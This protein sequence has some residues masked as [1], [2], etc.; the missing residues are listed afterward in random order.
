MQ[1]IPKRFNV[2]VVGVGGSGSATVYELAKRNKRVLGIERHDIPHDLG[3]S[4]GYTL[5]I[6]LAY[7][8]HPSYV[9]LLH[10]S[11]Q[12]WNEIERRSGEQIL[13]VHGS[14]DAG[15]ADS[16]VFTGAMR[17]AIEFDL[18]HTV[19]T[20]L[21]LNK[22][23]PGYHLPNDTMALYQPQGGYLLPERCIVNYVE[24]AQA[25]GAEVHGREAVLEW[26]PLREGGV[27]VRTDRDVYEADRLVITA[28]AWAGEMVDLM[29]GLLVPERQ[30]LAWL[31]PTKPQHF[32]P[33]NF[34]VFN[35]LVPE[36]RYY[37]FPVVHVPGF[38]FG[39]YHHLE[40]R[41]NPNSSDRSSHLQDEQLLRDFADRYFPDGAGPT[42]S[43]KSCIFTNT[44]DHHFIIDT[45]P[46]YPQVSFAS[47]CS[48]H[49]FKFV[50]VL[51][52]IMADLAERGESRHNIDFFSLARYRPE[53]YPEKRHLQRSALPAIHTGARAG[54][55]DPFARRQGADGRRHIPGLPLVTVGDRYGAGLYGP[56][57][58]AADTRGGQLGRMGESL[59]AENDPAAVQPFW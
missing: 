46:R 7:Y 45:H 47:P 4:L 57:T 48:G 49:G 56:Y 54:H 23:F 59:S 9:N 51:G 50:S 30:V 8:E 34:P 38:K 5:I 21:E 20:G 22:R 16:P 42:M 33:E 32:R 13:H 2:I 14:I 39:R 19:Y 44:P 15:P 27:R 53:L 10:R 28:G 6:R 3:S 58:G 41:I 36:G 35:C 24:V 37:G 55:D 29:D 43:L 52:E 12:L 17:S 18:E 40:E 1:R 31:Q 11:Y 25:L 26:Q